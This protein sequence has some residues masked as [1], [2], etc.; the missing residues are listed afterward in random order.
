M[1]KFKLVQK[2]HSADQDPRADLFPTQCWA[3]AQYDLDRLWLHYIWVFTIEI[4]TIAIYTHIF[5]HLQ[6]RLRTIL[7][8]THHAQTQ[9][10]GSKTRLS[11]AARYMVLY[12]LIYVLL[13]LPL[14]AGRMASM[15]GTTPPDIYYCIAGSMMTSCGW[16]DSLL[17]TLTRRV[18]VK[19]DPSARDRRSMHP[20]QSETAPSTKRRWMSTGTSTHPSTAPISQLPRWPLSSFATI[21]TSTVKDPCGSSD[22]SDDTSVYQLRSGRDTPAGMLESG[23]HPPLG[24]AVS[25]TETLILRGELQSTIVEDRIFSETRIEVVSVPR[26]EMLANDQKKS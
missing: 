6:K 7:S 13:T 3:G 25:Q 15:S 22:G 14:A 24:A 12:P 17:Y 23:R 16:L 21:D 11:Q 10:G 19:S 5:L 1:G 9:T 8:V 26:E 4:G 18:F 2:D 20:I